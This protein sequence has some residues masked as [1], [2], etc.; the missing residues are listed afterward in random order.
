MLNKIL[1]LLFIISA[2]LTKVE[3][4][5][6]NFDP[7]NEH[8]YVGLIAF[9]DND[10][11]FI[12]RCTGTVLS[13]HIFLTAGHCVNSVENTVQ[14]TKAIVWFHQTVTPPNPDGSLVPNLTTGYADFCKGSTTLCAT[15]S[16][17]ERFPRNATDPTNDVAIA[18]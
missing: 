1:F 4:V 12:A 18:I 16:N 8:P 6:G 10:N 13:K 3:A 2:F 7:D 11:N 9:Y 5:T 14:P 17:L 15:S